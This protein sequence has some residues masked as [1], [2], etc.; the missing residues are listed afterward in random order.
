MT[1]GLFRRTA[2]WG[3]LPE[4]VPLLALGLVIPWTVMFAP[5]SGGGQQINVVFAWGLGTLDPFHII[6]VTDYLLVYTDGLP[7]RLLA[8]PA[9]TLLYLTALV[10]VML[11]GRDD[12]RVTAGLLVIAGIAHLGFVLGI[13]RTTPT[14]SALIPVGPA[15][16]WALVWWR[17]PEAFTETIGALVRP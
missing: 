7:D 17:Y 9:G 6:T 11:P 4:L 14:L 10:S 16:C 13:Y 5:A 15:A 1:A 3:S 12:R 2:R 8:W